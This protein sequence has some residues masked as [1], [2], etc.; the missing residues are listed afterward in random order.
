MAL[1]AQQDRRVGCGGEDQII[2][3]IGFIEFVAFIGF[4]KPR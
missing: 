2:A 1:R 4:V 3:F